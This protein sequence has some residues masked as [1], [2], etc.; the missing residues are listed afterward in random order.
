MPAFP[1]G[2]LQPSRYDDVY[3]HLLPQDGMQYTGDDQSIGWTV[4]VLK[5]TH[6]D[7][8]EAVKATGNLDAATL[9]GVETGWYLIHQN[10]D[11]VIWVYYYGG[12]AG[13]FSHWPGTCRIDFENADA[14]FTKFC[15]AVELP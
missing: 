5:I 11:G 13:T 4:S 9:R 1:N 15:E 6:H 14:E 12:R 7:I 2:A 10:S 8:E 3:R